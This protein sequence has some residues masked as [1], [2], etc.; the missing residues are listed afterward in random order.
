MHTTKANKSENYPLKVGTSYLITQCKGTEL[1]R[2]IRQ[3][4]LGDEENNENVFG[5]NDVQFRRG[6]MFRKKQS[7]I[8]TATSSI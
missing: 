1:Y 2:N 7:K 4:E 8:I 6:P 5:R 3:L